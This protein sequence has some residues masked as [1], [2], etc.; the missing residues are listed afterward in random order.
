[1]RLCS[2]VLGIFC[3]ISSLP[4]SANSWFKT[5]GMEAYIGPEI[6]YAERTKEGGAKQNGTLYGFRLGYDR[7]KRYK[8][9]W[10]A[11]LLFATGILE[12]SGRAGEHIKFKSKSQLT[13]VNVEGRFGYTFQSKYW[14]CASLTPFAGYGYFWEDNFYKHPTPMHIHFKNRFSYIPFGF[15]SQIF[16]TPK[17]SVGANV[18]IRYLLEASQKVSHDPEH[19]DTVQHYVNKLQYRIEVPLTYFPCLEMCDSL[20]VSLVPFYE[21]R[22]YGHLANFPF[23]FLETKLTLWGA[24]LKLLYLF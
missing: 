13:D 16:I 3:F 12:G 10:A 2:I 24:T 23:D 1:M 21:C 14:R 8:W 9:Y 18:K 6:Y 15:L 20:A 5:Y 11:D 17:W 19:E 7:V 4:L 22:P